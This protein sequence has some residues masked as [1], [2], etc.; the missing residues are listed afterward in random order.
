MSRPDSETTPSAEAPPEAQAWLSGL[1]RPVRDVLPLPGDVSPRRYARV[2]FADGGTAIL[3]AYPPEV[4]AT[5]PRFLRTTGLL[6]GAGVPV[7][8]VLAS[9]CAAGFMLLEDLGPQ[10]LADWKGRPWSELGPYFQS[11]LRLGE[12]IARLPAAEVA[13]LNPPLGTE[14]LRRELAQTWDLFLEPRGLTGDATLTAALRAALDDL[15][16]RLGAEPLVPCHR[17]FMSRNLMPID[18]GDD[19][20]VGV[21]VLD[22]QDLRLG[23][24]AYD[25]AS[26]LN[27]TLFP[28]PSVEE[29]LLAAALPHLPAA[30]GE[31]PRTAYHR[32]AAQRTLKAVGTYT[33]FALRGADRHLPLVGPTLTRCLAHLVR[34]PEGEA[35]AGD[36]GRLWQPVL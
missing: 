21:A 30:P 4:R 11:A 18:G 15:C 10:T 16:A 23:P 17:D 35:L 31:T 28:P 26:L 7:P 12:R 19:S 5:C 34:I 32:A 14:L 13:D 9:D 33:S 36:L 24:A 22:H 6:A 29:E 27:D 8:R 25:L 1:G 3:A 20:Q 2:R